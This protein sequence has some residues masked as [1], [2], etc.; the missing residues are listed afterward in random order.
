MLEIR[1]LKN[2]VE[3][4][5]RENPESRNSDIRLTILIWKEFYYEYI[6]KDKF[7]N[8]MI[9]LESLYNLPNQDN[10]KRIR[11]RFQSCKN[12][13]PRYLPTDWKIAKQRGWLQENWRSVLNYNPELREPEMTIDEFNKFNQ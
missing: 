12:K 10:I 5:L 1:Q 3:H 11:A 4:F 2:Q 7:G 13:S 9:K 6:Y 8:E